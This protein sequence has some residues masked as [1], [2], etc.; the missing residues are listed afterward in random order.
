MKVKMLISIT[1]TI[2]GQEWPARGSEVELADQVAADLIAN[3]YAEPCADA[4]V[5]TAKI[6]TAAVDPVAETAT[7]PAAKPRKKADEG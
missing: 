6:E 4:R 1:G 7:R 2:D 5:R 3:G